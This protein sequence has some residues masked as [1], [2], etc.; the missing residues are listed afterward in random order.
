MCI[1]RSGDRS[2]VAS[3][4]V[5]LPRPRD[6]R[7]WPVNV[8]GYKPIAPRFRALEERLGTVVPASYRNFLA[9]TNG[10]RQTTPFIDR[11]WSREEVDWF[12]VRNQ[13]W[14]DAWPVDDVP[15][16]SDEEY[17]I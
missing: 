16:V 5:R 1:R 8:D 9:T 3:T 12:A 13:D 17:F 11:L 10:Y 15:P 4:R 7:V 6:C 14:I 2:A